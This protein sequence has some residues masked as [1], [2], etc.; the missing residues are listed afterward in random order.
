MATREIIFKPHSDLAIA[1]GIARLLIQKGL[2]NE[3]F[4]KKH[5][6]FM[7]GKEDIGYGLE[8][9]FTFRE[10]AKLVDFYAYEEYVS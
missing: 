4:L 1:N 8:D 6:L 10:E 9:K 3:Q 5:V 2:I 7:R